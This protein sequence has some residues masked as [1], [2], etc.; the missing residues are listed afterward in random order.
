MLDRSLC[1]EEP[2]VKQTIWMHDRNSCIVRGRLTFINVTISGHRYFSEECPEEEEWCSHCLN[3]FLLV[4]EDNDTYHTVIEHHYVDIL[5]ASYL[6]TLEKCLYGAGTNLFVLNSGATLTFQDSALIDLR[7]MMDSVVTLQGG[8]LQLIRVNVSRIAAGGIVIFIES[9][10]ECFLTLE[11]SYVNGL[12]RDHVYATDMLPQGGFLASSSPVS[13]VIT[14]STFR[15]N[16]PVGQYLETLSLLIF[17]TTSYLQVNNTLFANCIGVVWL[18]HIG[19]KPSGFSNVTFY[20]HFATVVLYLV[21][22]YPS[23]LSITNC[24]FVNSQGI[25]AVFYGIIASMHSTVFR[26]NCLLGEYDVTLTKFVGS[27]VNT[28]LSIINCT[29]ENNGPFHSSYSAYWADYYL[30]K[31]LL[32]DNGLTAERN[33]LQLHSSCSVTVYLTGVQSPSIMHSSF[34]NDLSPPCST[35]LML[36]NPGVDENDLV[37]LLTEISVSSSTKIAL[38]I[39]TSGSG[40]EGTVRIENSILERAAGLAILKFDSTIDLHA[41]NVTFQHASGIISDLGAVQLNSASGFFTACLWQH[42]QGTLVGALLIKNSNTVV[43]D[44]QFLNN[45]CFACPS[46]LY[47]ATTIGTSV[48][49]SNCNFTNSRA[50]LGTAGIFIIGTLVQAA[51]VS[52]CIFRGSLGDAGAVI[53]AMHSSGTFI[54]KNLTFQDINSKYTTLIHISMPLLLEP[55]M[56]T[57]IIENLQVH[58]N[59]FYRGIEVSALNYWPIVS[60]LFCRFYGNQGSVVWIS[61][62]NY[63]DFDS[64]Y[65][66]NSANEALF[67]QGRNT[68]VALTRTILIFNSLSQSNA[69]L[70]I[71]GPDTS[72]SCKNCSFTGTYSASSTSVVQVQTA[73]AVFLYCEFRENQGMAVSAMSNAFL[74]MD[75]C[76]FS[77][78]T[79]VLLLQNANVSITFSSFAD[80]KM[81]A[82][83]L[84]Q[85][86]LDLRNINLTKISGGDRCLLASQSSALYLDTALVVDIFC[87]GTSFNFVNSN[88]SVRNVVFRQM[89]YGTNLLVII[90]GSLLMEY[91]D[92]SSANTSHPL[93]SSSSADLHLRDVSVVGIASQVIEV[94]QAQVTLERCS[95]THIDTK[96]ATGILTCARCTNIVLTNCSFEHVYALSVAGIDAS[97][98]SVNVQSSQFSDLQAYDSGALHISADQ[99]RVYDTVFFNNIAKKSESLGGALH[100]NASQSIIQ[101]TI[102]SSNSANTGGAI[103]WTKQ[104]PLLYDCEFNNNSAYYGPD[105]ASYPSV[106]WTA[107]VSMQLRSGRIFADSLAI[108]LKDPLGQIVLTDSHTQGALIHPALSGKLYAVASSGQILFTGFSLLD[109]PGKQLNISVVAGSLTLNLTVTLKVCEAGEVEKNKKCFLCPTAT[110][111][112]TKGATECNLCPLGAECP[113][114]IY[115]YPLPGFWRP[116]ELYEGVFRCPRP[117]SCRGHEN[118]TSETGKCDKYYTGHMCQSCAQGASRESRDSCTACPSHFGVQLQAVLLS[119]GMLGM[120]QLLAW[121]IA[122]EQSS[123][124]VLLLTLLNYVQ[125]MALVTDF[126]LSWPGSL[127]GFWLLHRYVGNAAQNFLLVGCLYSDTFFITSLAAS[128][129]PLA[130]T[131]LYSILWITLY[132]CGKLLKLQVKSLCLNCGYCMVVGLIYTHPFIVR[133]GL[134]AFLCDTIEP[135]NQW[136]RAELGVRCWDHMHS[137]Y[138]LSV[139]L[140]SLLAWGLG[141]PTLAALLLFRYRRKGKRRAEQSNFLQHDFKIRLCLWEIYAVLLKA[142]LA[143]LYVC[144]ANAEPFVQASLLVLAVSL[145]F[146]L[147]WTHKPLQS[148]ACNKLALL[149]LAAVWTSTYAGLFFSSSDT[150]LFLSI[151]VFAMHGAF[152]V[153][154]ITAVVRAAIGKFHS[155]Y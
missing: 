32:N 28:P 16:L 84:I 68:S 48:L 12:N 54:L 86:Q 108:F 95:F 127:Q 49:I 47:I 155:I 58:L 44:S 71:E 94:T 46:D 99:F 100:L 7:Y 34:V 123:V 8:S 149:S 79:Q 81:R 60:C 101:R 67:Y 77:S 112:L 102:F 150:N 93:L 69:G 80:I 30:E 1:D 55:G 39:L 4:H 24:Q 91:T 23:A 135:E 53:K 118:K 19:S 104:A 141:L 50:T 97:A 137:T 98:N 3:P 18:E 45:S 119:I 92:I 59:T 131:L 116:S 89:L 10:S 151:V 38:L 26:N 152:L 120:W 43:H 113:G 66:N 9:D 41:Y 138:A 73:R 103:Y 107:S 61:K 78:Q 37:A 64:V 11:D 22:Q 128:L 144:T 136:L 88:V 15:E 42:N 126:E 148:T 52:N 57:T 74:Y 35:M 133:L 17:A 111:S 153:Y 96:Q 147:Q 139:S 33:H 2:C 83:V 106:L 140:P 13:L 142:S 72:F 6:E 36:Y 122:K 31:G 62:G 129:A 145:A 134:S 40:I 63:S 125:L 146:V 117:A 70:D 14:G 75:H 85:S 87:S 132:F 114:G 29:F 124:G 115:L 20:R 105:Q 51:V 76:S 25:V 90:Q 110:Y 65:A 109:Q 27:E 130:I 154:W 56:S 121:A 82:I 5:D 143:I 21:G